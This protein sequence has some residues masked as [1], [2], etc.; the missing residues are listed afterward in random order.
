MDWNWLVT[1]ILSIGTIC[2]F[3]T[4]LLRFYRVWNWSC[5][6][7][8]SKL[9]FSSFLNSVSISCGSALFRLWFRFDFVFDAATLKFTSLTKLNLWRDQRSQ[10]SHTKIYN[11]ASVSSVTSKYFRKRVAHSEVFRLT[12]INTNLKDGNNRYICIEIYFEYIS[13]LQK[14]I[15]TTRQGFTDLEEKYSFWE[16]KIHYLF[17]KWANAESQV[18]VAVRISCQIGSVII[19]ALVDEV[20]FMF[21]IGK[22]V[23]NWRNEC[24]K[25]AFFSIN[26]RF[27]EFKAV[28]NLH[29]AS[30][31][32][33]NYL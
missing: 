29:D 12:E 22:S 31:F 24:G 7:D 9:L 23:L 1:H 26:N 15:I 2:T 13:D 5:W 21:C 4:A 30:L 17:P 33:F 8:W 18:E 27:L 20:R 3:A 32:L 16:N 14:T 28:E 10:L 25:T 19:F 11:F 6:E